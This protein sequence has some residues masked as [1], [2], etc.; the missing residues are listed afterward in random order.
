MI[1]LRN[2]RNITDLPI[3]HLDS[4]VHGQKGEC[5][6]FVAHVAKFLQEMYTFRIL[7]ASSV[8]LLATCK[9]RLAEMRGSSC[10]ESRL[11]AVSYFA[12]ASQYIERRAWEGRL[13]SREEWGRKPQSPLLF[14]IT[15]HN[16]TFPLTALG[17][18]KR[19][20]T[21]RNLK[22]KAREKE[23]DENSPPSSRAHRVL[24]R[25]N[26]PLQTPAMKAKNS[27]VSGLKNSD[28]KK[29]QGTVWWTKQGF[30]NHSSHK[31]SILTIFY[32]QSQI[33]T[34]IVGLLLEPAWMQLI[35]FSTNNFVTYM[36]S[37][38]NMKGA[39]LGGRNSPSFLAR[40]RVLLYSVAA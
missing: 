13:R 14:T 32:W 15:L 35:K 21:A 7:L 34:C 2:A 18:K 22:K 30:S 17:S 24:A 33:Y 3:Q 9:E 4:L 25:P 1:V 26:S 31:I 38:E 27:R 5:L 6:L 29:C 28:F 40:H 20:T 36:E 8:G 19:K 23:K 11:R 12:F 10:T 39:H 37:T 16:F